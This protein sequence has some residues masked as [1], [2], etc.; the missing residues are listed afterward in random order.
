MKCVHD[1]ECKNNINDN[2]M[3]YHNFWNTKKLQ[4]VIEFMFSTPLIKEKP[5]T[6]HNLVPYII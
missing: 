3:S 6:L 4:K 2:I 5:K 1:W